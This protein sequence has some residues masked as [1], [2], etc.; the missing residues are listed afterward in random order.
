MAELVDARV[1][2]AR[3]V[4]SIGSSP[5]T[6]TRAILHRPK[7]S[8]ARQ[9]DQAARHCPKTRFTGQIGATATARGRGAPRRP[10]RIRPGDLCGPLPDHPRS[11]SLACAERVPLRR[12]SLTD[13]PPCTLWTLVPP[14]PKNALPRFAQGDIYHRESEHPALPSVAGAKAPR[15]VTE[16][17]V[18]IQ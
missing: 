3:S 10:S 8:N 5:I 14:T 15:T 11:Q 4:R 17:V 18:G 12:S 16:P 6:R 9:H 2:G 13:A 1:L 7:R